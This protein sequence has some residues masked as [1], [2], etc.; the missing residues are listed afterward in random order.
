[1]VSTSRTIHSSVLTNSD[2]GSRKNKPN[3]TAKESSRLF[4]ML[5]PFDSDSIP[6]IQ[7]IVDTFFT[8]KPQLI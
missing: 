5:L 3:D 6:G 7:S 4:F 2:K 8:G 1:M